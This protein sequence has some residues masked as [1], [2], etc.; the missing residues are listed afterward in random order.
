MS[1]DLRD[2]LQELQQGGA[3]NAAARGARHDHSRP[4]RRPDR[5]RRQRRRQALCNGGFA[6]DIPFTPQRLFELAK[7]DGAILL[8]A[9]CRANP[10]GERAPHARSVASDVRDRHAPPHRRAREPPDGRARDLRLSAPRGRESLP[11]GR[12]ITLE[13]TEVVLAKANQALQT[14]QRYRPR[15]DEV[16]TA[17][18]LEFDDLVTV[19]D[20]AEVVRRFEMVRRV[21]ARSPAT[22]ASSDRRPACADAGRRA[23]GRV[24]E[25]YLC[26][27]ATT[28]T[29]LVRVSALRSRRLAELTPEQLLDGAA[30]AHAR[31]SPRPT[32]PSSTCARAATVCSAGPAVARDSRQPPRRPLRVAPVWSRATAPSSTTS[33]ASGPAGRRP[34]RNGLRRIRARPPLEPPIPPG[35]P[36]PRDISASRQRSLSGHEG[37][38]RRAA[39][40]RIPDPCVEAI[41]RFDLW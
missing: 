14:L 24:D 1:E 19:G 16:S 30:V 8:D 6:I 35:L 23:H 7:M 37:R 29:T 34:S 17:D 10:A 18:A 12:R 33:T 32:S 26:S 38:W 28:W 39:R 11:R 4:N 22:S 31:L 40:G 20:V 15:L 27:C 2:S 5:H 36:S 25:E 21:R 3:G 41:T 13:D 9:D